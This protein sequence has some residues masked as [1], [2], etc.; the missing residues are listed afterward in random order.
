MIAKYTKK[1]VEI[2]AIKFEY[3]K[4]CL[5]AI[6]SFIG[7]GELLVS[8]ARSP[9]AKAELVVPTLEDG[10][11][12]QVRHIATEGDMIIKG[13][14]GEFYPCKPEIFKATYTQVVEW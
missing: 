9:E 1:P 5:E 10:S 6:E 4:E 7:V 2:E 3:T 11:E 12:G 8:K 14:A 13:V